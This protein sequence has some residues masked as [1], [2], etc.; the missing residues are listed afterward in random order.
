MRVSVDQTLAHEQL[1]V[2]NR[3][4]E[5][6]G[7]PNPLMRELFTYRG[8]IGRL[9]YF[10]RYT[11]IV[12]VIILAVVVTFVLA[13]TSGIFAALLLLVPVGGLACVAQ[14]MLVIRRLHDLDFSGWWCLALFSVNG[15]GGRMLHSPDYAVIVSGAVIGLAPSLLLWFKRGTEGPN[16][17]GPPSSPGSNESA[18]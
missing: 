16:R 17:F 8:R 5:G 7:N 14:T 9:T 10:W 3:A 4:Y 18:S 2:T 12:L 15:V 6:N 1:S 11:A 13:R